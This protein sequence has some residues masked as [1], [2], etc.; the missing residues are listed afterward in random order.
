MMNLLLIKFYNN[1]AIIHIQNSLKLSYI[2]QYN[3]VC[4]VHG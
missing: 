1:Y 4:A 3:F 2:K